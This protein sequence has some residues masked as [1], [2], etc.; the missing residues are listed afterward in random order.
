M[1]QKLV[2]Y[3]SWVQQQQQK[4]TTKMTSNINNEWT[5]AK[6]RTMSA[7]VT[8]NP[9]LENHRILDKNPQ[10]KKSVTK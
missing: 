4:T 5:T 3:S 2:N 9:D 7:T 10:C 6:T 8:L 1:I